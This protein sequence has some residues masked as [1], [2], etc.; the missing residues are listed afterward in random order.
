[1]MAGSIMPGPQSGAEGM[2]VMPAM[3]ALPGGL[4]ARAGAGGATGPAGAG[5]AATGKSGTTGSPK[6]GAATGGT[7]GIFAALLASA[8][9][10]AKSGTAPGPSGETGDAGEAAGTGGQPA[11]PVSAAPGR[12]AAV[13]DGAR[14]S[15]EAVAEATPGQSPGPPALP[16]AASEAKPGP[17]A[18]AANPAPTA[19]PA[20]T[21]EPVATPEPAVWVAGVTRTPEGPKQ[22]DGRLDRVFAGAPG[23][24]EAGERRV[25]DP[26]PEVGGAQ[27]AAPEATGEAAPVRPTLGPGTPGTGVPPAAENHPERAEADPGRV[28]RPE[29][30]ADPAGAAAPATA[31]AAVA[32]GAPEA[33]RGETEA[34]GAPVK[35]AADRQAPARRSVS[36]SAGRPVAPAKK[37]EVRENGWRAGAVRE[38]ARGEA[39]PAGQ[40][41]EEEARAAA[42]TPGGAKA[43]AAEEAVGGATPDV[44]QLPATAAQDPAS[45]RAEA[46]PEAHRNEPHPQ[47]RAELKEL[48]QLVRKAELL[49]RAEGPSEMRLQLV[50]EHLGRLA[51]RVS[52]D[53]GVVTAR[54]VV[55]NPEVKALVEQRLSEL[56]RSLQDQGLRLTNVSVGCESSGGNPNQQA[57]RGQGDFPQAAAFAPARR[58]YEELPAGVP[59]LA[60]AALTHQWRGSGG[61]VDAL[62]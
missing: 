42:A 12:Q 43:P 54:L 23:A 53:G 32:E 34:T 52:V 41:T 40:T 26:A 39:A 36:T 5:L 3:S 7:E 49:A 58:Q 46:A 25:A 59:G 47:V 16:P 55:E 44:A 50:P 20:V 9:A 56:T 27:E 21:A 19:G 31:V 30:P 2:L 35:G 37:S 8:L 62:V 22:A 15:G 45:R 60:H 17:P 11:V 6:A 28:A 24:A 10:G 13:Q 1:M 38:T 57:W 4:G 29:G 51:V 48:P 14:P 33:A 18:S 61:V